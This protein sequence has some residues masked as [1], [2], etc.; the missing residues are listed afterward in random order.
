MKLIISTIIELE[1]QFT[2]NVSDQPQCRI[3]LKVLI[4]LVKIP[5]SNKSFSRTRYTPR[6]FHWVGVGRGWP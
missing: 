4:Y 2:W 5:T 6:I 3:C 1:L